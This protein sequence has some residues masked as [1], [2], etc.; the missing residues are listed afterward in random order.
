MHAAFVASYAPRRCGIATFTADTVAAVRAADPSTR[1]SVYAITELGARHAYDGSVVGTI[2][3]GDVRSY[4]AAARAIDASAAEVVNVQHEFGLYGV[5]RDGRFEDHLLPLL[6]RTRRPTVTTLHTVVARPE[7]W[8]REAVRD[9]VA[10]ST[11]TVVMVGTAARLLHEAYGISQP[12]IVIPHG[13]PAVGSFGPPRTK[14]ELGLAGRTV[15]TTFGLV[16][17]RK[18]L[19]YAIEAMPAVVA[20]HPDALYVIAGQTHPEVV[21]RD[22]ET[23]R[24]TLRALVERLGLAGHV[25]FEDRYLSQREIV[26]HLA[27]TDV[28]VAPYLDPDQISSGTLA[29]AMGAGRAVVSTPYLHAREALAEGRGTLVPFRDAAAI[30]EAINATLDDGERRA[31]IERAAAAYSAGTAWPI[32]GARV[33]DVMRAAARGAAKVVPVGGAEVVAV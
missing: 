13:M 29:Y 1:C 30:A 22:G 24:D 12:V 19:E 31:R 23:Y 21:R 27:A 17:R 20:R 16:D 6:E 5:H 15:I 11:V 10:A 8:M 3:Q 9:I 33:L 18:G 4:R 26:D 2:A 7:R 32:V 28:Y 25:A 14:A